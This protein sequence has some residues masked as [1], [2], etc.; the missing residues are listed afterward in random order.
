MIGRL[1]ANQ[2][3][4]T[5]DS[6][7]RSRNYDLI[8]KIVSNQPLENS[9]KHHILSAAV[10]EEYEVF[11]SSLLETGLFDEC[12]K[13]ID[14]DGCSILHYSVDPHTI[15]YLIRHGDNMNQVSAHGTSSA[16]LG[17]SHAKTAYERIESFRK[18]GQSFGHL[19]Q[20]LHYRYQLDRFL[21]FSFTDYH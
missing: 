6:W 20:C 18:F 11:I 9:I 1:D 14:F 2:L 19:L 15:I 4:H 7:I 3:R 10:G 16:C 17:L 12:I 5:F 8:I 13:M 21:S